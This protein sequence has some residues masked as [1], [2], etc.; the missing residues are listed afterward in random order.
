MKITKEEFESAHGFSS[1][2]EDV[3]EFISSV[4]IQPE[5]LGKAKNVSSPPIEIGQFFHTINWGWHEILT[6]GE[7]IG[8]RPWRAILEN[9]S[10]Q[11]TESHVAS[12]KQA[13]SVLS[14]LILV[15]L[16]D[17]N[18]NMHP[19]L[20]WRTNSSTAMLVAAISST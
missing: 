1:N 5:V 13:N 3:F 8:Y 15:A 2:S 10:G 20:K 7:N 4:F 17:E 14:G 6:T 16:Q 12:F 11:T 18:K 19:K 9:T